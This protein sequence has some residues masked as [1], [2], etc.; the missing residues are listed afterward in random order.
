MNNRIIDMTIKNLYGNNYN[1]KFNSDLT[2]LYGVNGS[3]K[4]TILEIIFLII[5]GQIQNVFRYKFDFLSVNFDNGMLSI[6]SNEN[7]YIVNFFDEEI[8]IE[9][10]SEDYSI[11][12]HVNLSDSY[13]TGR[14]ESDRNEVLSFSAQLVKLN[15][16]FSHRFELT[17]IP[18]NRKIRGTEYSRN[19]DRFLM[20]KQERQYRQIDKT[21]N[22]TL[23]L[24]N[25]YY[26]S[27][28]DSLI[29]EERHLQSRLEKNILEKMAEPIENVDI[30]K[31]TNIMLDIGEM[32]NALLLET[33]GKIK[34]NLENLFRI[35]K[36]STKQMSNYIKV[37]AE[38][39][40]NGLE[41]SEQFMEYV[42]YTVQQQVSYFQI[43]KIYQVFNIN[44]KQRKKIE[45]KKLKLKKTLDHI[46]L[47][48]KDTNK[49]V[50][51][52]EEKG[53]F[54]LN[55]KTNE[56]LP[57]EYLSSG[58]VQLVIFMV[59]SLIKNQNSEGNKILL[60]DEPELSMHISWQEKLLPLMTEYIDSSQMIIATHSPDVIGDKRDKC[61]E[62]IAE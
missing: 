57:L 5:S 51:F 53:L 29:R 8:I 56:Q 38:N 41:T 9:K 18:L 10:K 37:F 2:I 47:L 34:D 28:E 49:K 59:F 27:N 4:T 20:Q 26:R 19:R 1:I 61:V 15:K 6:S 62:V 45:R 48:L 32:E 58:E 40:A 42:N 43:E 44:S 22:D 25:R 24:A 52:N 36:E 30:N 54:F 17:Y 50:L 21:V 60:I 55:L 31:R 13:T 23:F 39:K 35:Y 7:L 46:N 12:K 16:R 33:S 3:G 11:G 14:I